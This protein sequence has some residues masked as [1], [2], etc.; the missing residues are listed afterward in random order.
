[1]S[2]RVITICSI[3]YG[4]LRSIVPRYLGDTLKCKVSKT[5]PH[6]EASADEE[7]GTL[8]NALGHLE[9]SALEYFQLLLMDL[10]YS[11]L[12]IHEESL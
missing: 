5:R 2:M 12:A 10:I 1:M 3:N 8:G 9:S 6:A 11:M 4:R 7:Y